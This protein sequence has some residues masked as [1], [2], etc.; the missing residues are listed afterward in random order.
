MFTSFRLFYIP[1]TVCMCTQNIQQYVCVHRI[2]MYID[3]PGCGF[4]GIW[5]WVILYI[6]LSNLLSLYIKIS[7]HLLK[8]QVLMFYTLKQIHTFHVVIH[9]TQEEE[10][11]RNPKL[12]YFRREVQLVFIKVATRN[13]TVTICA[14]IFLWNRQGKSRWRYCQK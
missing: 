13:D 6:L 8:V 1:I 9:F 7:S 10:K 11:N 14:L 5:K 12:Q 2:Y 3:S 4:L